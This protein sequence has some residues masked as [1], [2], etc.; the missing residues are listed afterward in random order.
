LC[1]ELMD[2]KEIGGG[3]QPDG[4]LELPFQDL[5]EIE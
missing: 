3:V 5:P 1:L 2:E 4:K